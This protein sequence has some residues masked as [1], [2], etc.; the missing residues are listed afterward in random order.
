MSHQNNQPSSRIGPSQA[1]TISTGSAASTAFGTQTY[2]IRIACQLTAGSSVFYRV[3]DGTPTAVT[4]DALLPVNTIEYVTVTPGQKIAVI[5][6]AAAA[7][8]L[9]VSEIT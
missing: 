6:C 1:V 8:S 7:G 5:G 9:S 2:Q 4:T 3:G